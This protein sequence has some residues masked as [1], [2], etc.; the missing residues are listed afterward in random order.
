[1]GEVSGVSKNRTLVQEFYLHFGILNSGV[2]QCIQI[3]L[4]AK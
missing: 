3:D 1:M 2:V 4:L